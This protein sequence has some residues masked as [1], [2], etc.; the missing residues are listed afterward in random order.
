MA[1]LGLFS[2]GPSDSINALKPALE[3][4]GVNV[5]KVKRTNSAFV[6]RAGDVIFNYGSSAMPGGIIG[7]AT[8][9]NN[10][11]AIGNASNKLNAFRA[12]QEAGVRTVEF[13]DNR[14]TAQAWVND[15]RVLVYA[16]T[17]LQGHSGEG[18]EIGYHN[19]TS[20][21]DAGGYPVT[22]E[23]PRAQLYTKAVMGNRREFRVHVFK[24]KIIYIQQK[25]RRDGWQDQSGYSNLV[26]NHASGWIY[27][28][29]SATPINAAAKR[30]AIK[31][32]AALGL[33]FGAVDIIT[34][35]EDAF[36]LEVNTAPGMTGTTLEVYS[37]ALSEVFAGNEVTG[38]TVDLTVQEPARANN[39]SSQRTSNVAPAAQPTTRAVPPAP[40]AATARQEPAQ[41][42]AP[43][44]QPARTQSSSLT[45]NN[46]YWLTV[47]D[48]ETI[49][50]FKRQQNCFFV[51][52]WE[53]PVERADATHVRPVSRA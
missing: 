7:Q 25:R 46:Y 37:R 40:S 1:K 2:H 34:N 16:R 11:S 41:Q 35:R 18:I 27:A 10:A 47:N 50:Q 44:P 43:A 48:E 28:T 33:D 52:G 19:P 45:D 51:I 12:L 53:V 15:D 9:L 23:L 14:Q 29:Q 42:A 38:E 21:G 24:G 49:G 32:V 26:R 4:M 8:V 36:V 13:T 22:A 20:V 6:G 5:K 39:T 30:E 3:A 17:R 31:S